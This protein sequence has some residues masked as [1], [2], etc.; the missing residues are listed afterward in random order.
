MDLQS[1][2]NDYNPGR[3]AYSIPRLHLDQKQIQPTEIYIR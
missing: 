1:L 3:V 2:P